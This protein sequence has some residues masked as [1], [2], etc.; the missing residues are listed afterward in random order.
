MRL[1]EQIASRKHPQVNT[2][3]MEWRSFWR[4]FYYDEWGKARPPQATVVSM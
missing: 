4:M 1:I 2:R 3:F